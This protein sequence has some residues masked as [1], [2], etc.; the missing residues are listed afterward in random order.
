M[1]TVAPFS[2]VFLSY[3]HQDESVAA[4]VKRT[5]SGEGLIVFSAPDVDLGGDILRSIRTRLVESRAVIV[6]VS[7]G[8]ELPPSVLVELG[9]AMA[10]ERPIFVLLDGV[11]SS[12]VPAFLRKFR[13]LPMSKL[14][15]IVDLVRRSKE[16]LTDAET[17][18]LTELYRDAGV[19]VDKLLTEPEKLDDLTQKF[20]ARFNTSRSSE[21]LAHQLLSIRKKGDLPPVGRKI[22]ST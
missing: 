1:S 9:A 7:P 6:I 4:T 2:D 11:A 20:N 21:Q 18:G 5:L 15:D 13:L 17:L 22:R 8:L 19:P 12:E 16:S 10:W 14:P 3:A